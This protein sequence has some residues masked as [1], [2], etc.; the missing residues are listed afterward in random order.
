MDESS[1]RDDSVQ[2]SEIARTVLSGP[3]TDKR[4]TL[5]INHPERGAKGRVQA[6]HRA[7]CRAVVIGAFDTPVGSERRGMSFSR[8]LTDQGF[9]CGQR[10]PKVAA[11]PK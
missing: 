2:L 8:R 6:T 10:P 9:S 1:S 5:T 11:S 7:A 3:I 4:D